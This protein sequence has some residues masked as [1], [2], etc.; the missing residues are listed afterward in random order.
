MHK[1]PLYKHQKFKQRKFTKGQ[2]T[3]V[4]QAIQRLHRH[5]RTR[6]TYSASQKPHI[7]LKLNPMF[8]GHEA[9]GSEVRRNPSDLESSGGK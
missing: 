3:L 7:L 9:L 1:H 4:T 5:E 8:G 2:A 6:I